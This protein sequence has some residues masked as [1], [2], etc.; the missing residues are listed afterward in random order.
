MIDKKEFAKIAKTY[1]SYALERRK[2]FA[3]SDELLAKSK[4]AIF[5]LHRDDAAAAK[6]LIS[7]VE[8]GERSF[9]PVFKRH[10][11][12]ASEG[13]HRAMVEEYSEARQFLSFIEGKPLGVIGGIDVD[14]DAVLGGLTDCVGEMAR[15]AVQWASERKDDKVKDTL[16]AAREIIAE[17]IGMNL[18]GYLRTKLDQAKGALRR[19]EDVAYDISIR[20]G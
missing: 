19:I 9:A 2:I 12:L 3:A 13:P 17:M 7:E 1:A 4:Q 14:A 5:A 10:P 8:A 15:K 20:R 11:D 18:T 6:K 16:A